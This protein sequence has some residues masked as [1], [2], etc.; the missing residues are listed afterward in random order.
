MRDTEHTVICLRCLAPEGH[1]TYRHVASQT[2]TLAPFA[3]PLWLTLGQMIVILLLWG[4]SCFIFGWG[5]NSLVTWRVMHKVPLHAV[6]TNQGW[7]GVA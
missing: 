1:G 6:H 4:V 3:K 5:M 7:R 2:Q